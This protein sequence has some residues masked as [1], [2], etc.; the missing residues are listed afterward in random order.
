MAQGG[1]TAA[2]VTY[3]ALTLQVGTGASWVAAFAG[4]R[5][6]NTTLETPPGGTV[7]RASLVD[8]VDEVAAFDTGAGI[9]TAP[10]RVVAVGGTASGWRAATV[11]L[12]GAPSDHP[13]HD[14][15][16]GQ[17]DAA[18]RHRIKA[19]ALAA[20]A[21][22]DG[23]SVTRGTWTVTMMGAPS[24]SGGLLTFALKIEH[25]GVDVTPPDLNPVRI[26]NPPILVDD[27]AGTIVQRGNDRETG[28]PY[29]RR[30]REAPM[31]AFLAIIGDMVR[32]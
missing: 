2:S 31:A 15:L 22:M 11:E 12:R 16:T 25:D 27:P 17:A 1:S 3:P 8:T 6:V 13:L 24:Y 32:P 28:L 14:A 4:H 21:N 9:A 20:L 18:E 23:Q 30:L 26:Y 10:Q 29:V 19:Q 7:L 5:S